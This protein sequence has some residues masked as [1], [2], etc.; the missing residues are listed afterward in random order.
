MGDL[1]Y[2]EAIVG[3]GTCSTTTRDADGNELTTTLA[4]TSAQFDACKQAIIGSSYYPA[5]CPR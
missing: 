2:F 4:V 3:Q 1:G 5:S